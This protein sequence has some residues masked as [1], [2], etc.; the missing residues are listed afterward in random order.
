MSAE[1]NQSRIG[2]I[3]S[4]AEG[5]VH[6]TVQA[7]FDAELSLLRQAQTPTKNSDGSESHLIF[8]DVFTRNQKGFVDRTIGGDTR[9]IYP[10]EA[11]G[12][13]IDRDGNFHHGDGSVTDGMG[14]TH[15]IIRKSDKFDKTEIY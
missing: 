3:A 12:E 7:V 14:N 2:F 15:S 9:I 11:E 1:F 10:N 8:K 4:R 5:R 6:P 13:Y